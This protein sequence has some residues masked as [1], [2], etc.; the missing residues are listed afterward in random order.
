VLLDRQLRFVDANRAYLKLRAKRLDPRD[1][2]DNNESARLLRRS[3]ERVLHNGE[4]DVIAFIRYRARAKR[5]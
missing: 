3:F 4:Q 1:P 2:V 5:R